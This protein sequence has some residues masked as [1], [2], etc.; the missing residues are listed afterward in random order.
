MVVSSVQVGR[1]AA[2]SIARDRAKK[3]PTCVSG[4]ALKSFGK[5]VVGTGS[6]A[7]HCSVLLFFAVLTD[8]AS[9]FSRSA[10]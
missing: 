3:K 10:V 8:L 1:S 2:Q 9:C 4:W 5:D 6:G 7:V